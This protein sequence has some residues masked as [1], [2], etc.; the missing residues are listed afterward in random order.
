MRSFTTSRGRGLG[1]SGDLLAF[2][3]KYVHLAVANLFAQL[4]DGST[5]AAAII[6]GDTPTVEPATATP[7][8]VLLRDVT[9]MVCA[10]HAPLQQKEDW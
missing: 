1:D 6:C 5:Y 7:K 8:S 4:A 3:L 2:V 9:P 10:A